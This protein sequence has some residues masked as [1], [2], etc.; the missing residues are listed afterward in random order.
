M[1]WIWLFDMHC[2]DHSKHLRTALWIK[3][4]I[5]KVSYIWCKVLVYVRYIGTR[6]TE[7][8]MILNIKKKA[9]SPF[10]VLKIMTT[11]RRRTS[12]RSFP[13]NRPFHGVF[14]FWLGTVSENLL[15]L[16]RTR[17]FIPPPWYKGRVDGTPPL[18][19]WYVAVYRNYFTFSWRP[20]I[21]L[22]RRGIFY[23]WWRCWRPVTSPTVFVILAAILDF[24]KNWK[25]G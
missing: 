10:L 17:K 23:G 21:F 24:I 6:F 16:G 1:S 25:S 12:K 3:V 11:E 14:N 8:F 19:F 15:T 18:S 2:S 5:S 22:T 7:F 4:D 9:S 13:Y 20:L